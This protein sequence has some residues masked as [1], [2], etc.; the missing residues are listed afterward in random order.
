MTQRFYQNSNIKLRIISKKTPT[1]HLAFRPFLAATLIFSSAIV[2]PGCAHKGLVPLSQIPVINRGNS[3]S[4]KI[5]SSNTTDSSL[6]FIVFGDNR[7][8][9]SRWIFLKQDIKGWNILKWFYKIPLLLLNPQEYYEVLNRDPTS[10][11]SNRMAVMQAISEQMDST[12]LVIHTGDIVQSGC[13]PKQWKRL[14]REY[15]P[16]FTVLGNGKYF[17]P[18]IGNHDGDENCGFG[19]F[20]NTFGLSAEKDTHY[21]KTFNYKRKIKY[22][23]FVFLDSRQF[24]QDLHEFRNLIDYTDKA[25]EDTGAVFKI[26]VMHH[27]PFSSG[28]HSGQW[29]QIKARRKEFIRIL[30]KHRVD[31]LFAGHD[32][33]YERSKLEYLDPQTSKRKSLYFITTAGGGSPLQKVRSLNE[34]QKIFGSYNQEAYNFLDPQ[35][36]FGGVIYEPRNTLGVYNFC[37]IKILGTKLICQTFK[38]TKDNKKL[39]IID[40]FTYSKN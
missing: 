27:P 22:T 12:D 14:Y 10:N 2:Y 4:G 24:F 8:P 11:K 3:G 21:I 28:R 32:H 35:E 1:Y 17:Y 5:A 16:I 34:R 13:Y 37:S 18:I 20:V 36:G 6:S 19:N 39:D 29:E 30:V 31:V 25:L 38:V 23:L 26:V 40:S 9:S 15:S 7:P 33:I